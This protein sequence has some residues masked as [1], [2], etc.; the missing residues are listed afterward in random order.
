M[1]VSEV[2]SYMMPCQRNKELLYCII[3]TQPAFSSTFGCN[4]DSTASKAGK[5]AAA[6]SAKLLILNH[7]S[8]K[9]ESDMALVVREAYDATGKKLSVLMS[10]DF[11]EVLVPWMGFGTTP[12]GERNTD[13]SS[14]GNESK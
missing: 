8:P 4:S 14:V 13:D 6:C 3:L 1:G 5:N 9:M 10:F 11:L 7:I 2:K 12:Q